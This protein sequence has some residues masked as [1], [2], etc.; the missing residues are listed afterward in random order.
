MV[1]GTAAHDLEVLGAQSSFS[2]RLVEGVGEADPVDGIL[3]DA[4]DHLGGVIPTIS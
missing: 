3:R 4:V 2:V 1:D